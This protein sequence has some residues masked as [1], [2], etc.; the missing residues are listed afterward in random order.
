[1]GVNA[2]GRRK[3]LGMD[4][5]SSEAETY[6][7]S[8]LQKLTLRGLRGVK[9]VISAV[10]LSNK[11]TASKVMNVTWQRCG[12]HFMRN[13]DHWTKFYS[14]NPIE[15]LNGRSNGAPVSPES[16]PTKLPSSA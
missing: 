15:R 10:H 8:L 6:W 5:G 7:T 9:L 16:F 1:M 12:V 2:V 3:V 4:I 14:N 13:A 11:V